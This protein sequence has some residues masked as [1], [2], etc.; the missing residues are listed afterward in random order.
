MIGLGKSGA[1][2]LIALDS[3]NA[4]LLFLHS[5]RSY[6][7]PK[8][9]VGGWAP[10]QTARI[11]GV[12]TDVTPASIPLGGSSVVVARSAFAP[13]ADFSMVYYATRSQTLRLQSYV[14]G[15]WNPLVTLFTKEELRGYGAFAITDIQAVRDSNQHL[16]IVWQ[17][18]FEDLENGTLV[19][20]LGIYYSKYDGE[21]ASPPER[22]VAVSYG[23]NQE[24]SPYFDPCPPV[25]DACLR[26]F[27]TIDAR[28]R[29]TL[30]WFTGPTYF[31]TRT[32]EGWTAPIRVDTSPYRNNI[33]VHTVPDYLVQPDLPLLDVHATST[34][35]LYFFYSVVAENERLL[36]FKY[37]EGAFLPIESEVPA[38]RHPFSHLDLPLKLFAVEHDSSDRFHLTSIG[39]MGSGT[40]TLFYLTLKE[41]F[42]PPVVIS[43]AGGEEVEL[44]L[45][46][47][48]RPHIVWRQKVE[49]EELFYTYQTEAGW[50]TPVQVTNGTEI[51]QK[52]GWVPP[53]SSSTTSQPPLAEKLPPP[54]IF[55]GILTISVFLATLRR[56]QSK[57]KRNSVK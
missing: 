52:F 11:N 43:D 15:R 32:A 41:Q 34:G 40:P 29:L 54:E 37:H 45:D 19:A 33:T 48:D 2:H 50:Q 36:V 27:L 23:P 13:S 44:S 25:F 30:A 4:E 53:V 22:V 10:L 26:I 9:L 16:H 47:N 49:Q 17:R 55:V 20:K 38:R 6:D 7:E 24:T 46:R 8:D 57:K 56:Y 28:D 35:D 31:T 18:Y 51:D 3:Q 1:P 21:R 42:S 14:N 5:Y 39:S 12:W